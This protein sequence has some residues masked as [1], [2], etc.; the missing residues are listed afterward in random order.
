[1]NIMKLIKKNMIKMEFIKINN[2]IFEYLQNDKYYL[3]NY[4]ILN[5]EDLLNDNKINFWYILLK[6]ILKDSIYKYR[7]SFFLKTKKVIKT[8]I[9]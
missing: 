3:Y 8:I 4:K 5:S 6:Y 1:M 2:S 7:I 9:T